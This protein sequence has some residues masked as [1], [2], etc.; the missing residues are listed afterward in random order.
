MLT[1]EQHLLMQSVAVPPIPP[2][3]DIPWNMPYPDLFAMEF[4]DVGVFDV[5]G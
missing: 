5:D 1:R 3:L 4:F 2:L